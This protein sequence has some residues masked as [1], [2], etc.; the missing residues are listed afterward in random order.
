[1]IGF[2]A[3]LVACSAVCGLAFV[4]V[5][6]PPWRSLSPGMVWLQ[7]AV[8]LVAAALDIVILLVI[9]RVHVPVLVVALILISQD[10]VFV[11]RI[12]KLLQVRRDDRRL[13]RSEE[14]R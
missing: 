2:F 1:M 9:L 4:A 10:V 7:S 13:A 12:V 5:L 3:A 11:W 8:A 14:P 6:G